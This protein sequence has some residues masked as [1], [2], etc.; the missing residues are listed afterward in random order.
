VGVGWDLQEAGPSGGDEVTG[1][2]VLNGTKVVLL[3]PSWLVK[4]VVTK[5]KP[6][7]VSLWIP[8]WYV[9]LCTCSSHMAPSSQALPRAEWMLKGT[10]PQ[11]FH[12]SKEKQ[13]G[14]SNC[15]FPFPS[16]GN[17]RSFTSVDSPA[18]VIS[19]QWTHICAFVSGFFHRA[20]FPSPIHLEVGVSAQPFLCYPVAFVWPG[21]ILFV[22]SSV[23]GHWGVSTLW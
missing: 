13:T 7:P 15:P 11:V 19:C 14:R 3:D 2:I 20:V 4:Q 21:H 16:P 9:F 22:H 6:V 1:N 18:Q 12:C 5:G 17:H 10:Q 23:D 8:D